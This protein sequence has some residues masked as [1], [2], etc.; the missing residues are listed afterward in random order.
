MAKDLTPGALL[1]EFTGEIT[2]EEFERHRENFG[3][4]VTE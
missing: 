2:S 3:A 1:N 4:E